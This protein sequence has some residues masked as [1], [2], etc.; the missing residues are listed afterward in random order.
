MMLLDIKNLKTYFYSKRGVL[1][2]VDD[3]SIAINRG[4]F[5]TI[6]GESGCGKSTLA[7]S[8]L[9]LIDYPG[10]IVG[11]N[12]FFDGVDLLK[13]SEERMREMRGKEIGMVF[14]DPMTSL[15][16]LEKIG[17]QIVE[18]IL[19]H[20]NIDKKEAWDMASKLLEKVGLPRDRVN[21][22]PHQLSGGQRQRVAIARAMILNP[23]FV[24]A[25]EP[26][27]MI[28]VSLRAA[29]LDLLMSFKAE[30]NLSMLF[31]T[32]DLSVARLVGDR[33]AVMYL[34][35]VVEIGETREVI[36]NPYHPYTAALLSAVPSFL[37]REINVEIIGDIANPRE[38]P[39]G[40]R[41][42]PRCPFAE[43][44]C[45]KEEPELEGKDHMVACHF[46]LDLKVD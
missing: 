39:T 19:E 26:V 5:I 6:V 18:T 36:H 2:A 31:I 23:K 21:Y 16:P 33:I 42:H 22:Y 7:Y 44:I 20:E 14:Q 35:K 27:S 40:C 46:P 29:I 3:V 11:G 34:G 1:K 37:K 12:I 28:D 43:E 13:I 41:Y 15:D 45:R 17:D 10:K 4:E 32:H 25:D 30:Y 8:I 9:R 38:I 24:V